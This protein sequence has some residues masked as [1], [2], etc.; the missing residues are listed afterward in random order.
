MKV[1]LH[2]AEFHA[3]WF[4]FAKIEKSTKHVAQLVQDAQ[5]E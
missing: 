4:G 1:S 5:I 3:N 2:L